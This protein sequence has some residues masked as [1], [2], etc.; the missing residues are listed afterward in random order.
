MMFKMNGDSEAA[1]SG[2]DF[3]NKANACSTN[4]S[5]SSAPFVPYSSSS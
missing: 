4:D 2:A 1:Q 5:A 3:K